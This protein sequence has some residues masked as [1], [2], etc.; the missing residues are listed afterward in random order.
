MFRYVRFVPKNRPHALA[1]YGLMRGLRT[2]IDPDE[3]IE[4]LDG[5]PHEYTRS[6]PPVRLGAT[7]ISLRD[8]RLLCPVEPTKIV[9]IGLNYRDHAAEQGKALPDGPKVF[10]KATSSLIGP[11]EVIRLNRHCTLVHHEAEL[12]IVIGT[13]GSALCKDVA[14]DQA[15]KF[16]AGFCVANDVTDR[17]IQKNEPTFAC[18]KG[19]DTFCPI[20]PWI[21]FGVDWR[22]LSIKTWV[23]EIPRQNGSTRDMVHS[24]P[25]L[26]SHIS[27][28]MTLYPGD[29]VLTGTP[30]GVGPIQK[31]DRVKIE[32]QD[33]GVLQNAVDA[34]D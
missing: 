25:R 21:A 6:E 34:G 1:Q 7:P 14:E 29:V 10:L 20:G 17:A 24:V 18:S 23:N 2:T 4:L 26:I 13:S 19:M 16:I 8:V 31:G 3:T 9:G 30:S 15:E 22:N 32:I 33:V 27:Q 12:G 11:D 28:F 5:P